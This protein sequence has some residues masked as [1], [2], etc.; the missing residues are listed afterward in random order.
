[1]TSRPHMRK[2]RSK[3]TGPE[4]RLRR[5]LR[6]LGLR[7]YRVHYAA[8]PGKPDVA[9]TRRKRAIFVHGCFWHGHDC[10]AGRNTPK[11]N[12]A[13]WEPK[14]AR[15]RKR[16]QK[17]QEDIRALGWEVLVVWECQIRDPETLK[18]TLKDFFGVS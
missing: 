15:N 17:I 12:L 14:L 6:E 10:P 18:E 5:L 16:D 11:T 8:L 1:M 4:I 7:G 13:Y 3:D 9:F 2:V